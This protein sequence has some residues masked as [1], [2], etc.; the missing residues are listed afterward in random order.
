MDV[1]VQEERRSEVAAVDM[2]RAME[3]IRLRDATVLLLRLLLLRRRLSV[4]TRAG[5]MAALVLVA[6][7]MDP[8]RVAMIH[9]MVDSHRD[10]VIVLRPHHHRRR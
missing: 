5:M 4:P 8:A 3:V 10:R 7:R 6:P 1:H 9:A 2:I